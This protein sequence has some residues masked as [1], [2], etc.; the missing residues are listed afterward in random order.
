MPITSRARRLFAALA[1]TLVVVLGLGI[2]ALT[3]ES[4][5]GDIAGDALYAAAAYAGL[6]LLLPRSR[7]AAVAI[8][9]AGWCVAVELLQLTG[10][11]RIWG[12]VF[13][14]AALLLGSGFDARDLVV[15][16]LAAVAAAAI[17]ARAAAWRLPRQHE[18]GHA[19]VSAPRPEGSAMPDTR[20]PPAIAAFID[21]TNAGDSEAF[22]SAFSENAVLSDWGRVFHGRQG[23]AE[24]DR[25]DNIGKRSHFVLVDIAPGNDPD[26]YVVTLTVSGDGYNGTGPMTI[27]LTDG[28][29][30][31]LTIA[32][33]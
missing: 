25:T 32:P 16:V 13:P 22:L 29:I 2:H 23:I 26:T 33:E 7:P 14:P 11:P 31:R 1:L 24:W 27:V 5:A 6:V 12:E 28:R 19:V 18:S 17:D 3:P 30:S 10:L 20:V 9:A 8:A 4:A 21:A 15:Y